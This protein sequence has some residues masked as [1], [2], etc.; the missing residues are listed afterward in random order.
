AFVVLCALSFLA[1]VASAPYSSLLPVYVDADLDRLPLFTG[2]LRAISLILGGLFAVVGGRMCDLFGLKTTLLLGLAGSALTGLVFHNTEVIALTG[3]VLVIGAAQGPLSTAGQ[4]Y[5]IAAAGPARLGLGGALY[6]LS[7]T[8]GNAVGS[9][10]TGLVKEDWTFSELGNVMTA[11]LSCVVV[12]G[13]L[14]LPATTGQRHAADGSRQR[15]ALWSSYRPLL[16]QS[17][18]HLLVGL[19]LSITTFWGMASLILPLLIFRASDSASTAAFYASVS[20]A[21]AA[22]GQLLTGLLRDRYGR[23]QPLLVSSTG[24]VVSAL[25]LAFSTESVPLLFVF[26]TA[27][28]TTAWAVSTLI[29]ALIAEV[30]TKAEKNRL[31]GL[32]HFVWSTAMVTGSLLGGWWVEIDPAI[33]FGF[34]AVSATIGTWCAWQ[35]CRRL[36]NIETPD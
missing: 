21:C 32:G 4:S 2:Y 9:F 23:T 28:T 33:P 27:L 29:P 6:F 31:V 16:R 14:L 18:V 24:I 36:R 12:L 35:L 8:F 1:G 13:V 11:T 34:G 3:L 25:C 30:A 20:L 17:N 19:R 26:G 22:G 10:V 7:G 5:L 15:M